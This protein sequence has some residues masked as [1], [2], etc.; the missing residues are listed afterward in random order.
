MVTQNDV[1][2]APGYLSLKRRAGTLLG[3]D[4]AQYSDLFLGRRF[5]VRLRATSLKDYESYALFLASSKE[6]QAALL[7]ELTIHTTHFWRDAQAWEAFITTVIPAILARKAKTNDK[8]I[9]VWCAGCSTGEE[10]VT[11]AICFHEALGPDLQGYRLTILGTDIDPATITRAKEAQYEEFQFREIPERLRKAYFIG[12]HPVPEIMRHL[13]YQVGD[14]FSPVKPKNMDII[15]C[16]NTVIYFEAVAKNKLY[17]EFYDALPP[18]GL[19]MM[20][21]TET[22]LGPAREKFTVLDMRERVFVK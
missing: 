2:S 14:I 3:F 10:P 9:R 21:K 1:V 20:G 22:L 11:V 6:E 12:N 5:D 18:G 13:T 4:M 16:R 8:T 15:I 17:V 7:K 19:F